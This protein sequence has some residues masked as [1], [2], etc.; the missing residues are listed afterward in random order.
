MRA[1]QR[2]VADVWLATIETD[3]SICQ[4]HG[5][6]TK[7]EVVAISTAFAVTA[8]RVLDCEVFQAEH[9]QAYLDAKKAGASGPGSRRPW[10]S[11]GMPRSS[12]RDLGPPF[13]RALI[14]RFTRSSQQGERAIDEPRACPRAEPRCLAPDASSPADA[15]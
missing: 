4:C 6:V 8:A 5:M 15:K 13:D 14:L 9:G 2:Q 12:T 1:L 7:A 3:T 11:S 10:C